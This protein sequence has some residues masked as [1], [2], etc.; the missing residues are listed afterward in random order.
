[1]EPPHYEV[2]GFERWK[3]H[4]DRHIEALGDHID[5]AIGAF[6]MHLHRRV[7]DHEPGDQCAELEIEQRDGTAHPHHAAGFGANLGDHLLG[8]FRLYQHGNAA[9][10]ELA[11]DLRH[12]EAA[13]RAVEQAHA[14]SF[15]HLQDAAAPPSLFESHRPP[16]P[17]P[18]PPLSP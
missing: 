11:A 18:P 13:G 2:G 3:A 5:P 8:G 17:P 9:V 6:Q 14:E 1:G 4:A 7:H 16:P 12:R 10:V 15:L